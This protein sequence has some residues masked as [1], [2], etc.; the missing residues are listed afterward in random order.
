M[1]PDVKLTVSSGLVFCTGTGYAAGPSAKQ[2]SEWEKGKQPKIITSRPKHTVL[3][4]TTTSCSKPLYLLISATSVSTSKAGSASSVQCL[5]FLWKLSA[6]TLS[7]F[8]AAY[9]QRFMHTLLCYIVVFFSISP[10]SIP[11]SDKKIKNQCLRR[12]SQNPGCKPAWWT[13]SWHFLKSNL[14]YTLFAWA[15]AEES[16]WSHTETFKNN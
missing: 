12:L 6:F 1:S 8:T 9:P 4:P 2:G 15:G 11:Q 14:F 5:L 3:Q 7:I 13:I 10:F 16:S